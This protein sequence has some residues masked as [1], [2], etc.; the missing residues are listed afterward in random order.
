M[1]ITAT[2]ALLADQLIAQG[3]AYWQAMQVKQAS[4]DFTRADLE[5]A[6]AKLNADIAALEAAIDAQSKK[7]S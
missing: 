7:S 3:L 6:A 4:G 5:E 1:A 2:E